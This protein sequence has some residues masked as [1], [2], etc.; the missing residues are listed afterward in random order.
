AYANLSPVTSWA[1]LLS[2]YYNNVG[3]SRKATNSDFFGLPLLARSVV[4]QVTITNVY[5]AEASISTPVNVYM[6]VV[7]RNI[8]QGNFTV[9]QIQ[10]DGTVVRLKSSK[11]LTLVIKDSVASYIN[12]WEAGVDESVFNWEV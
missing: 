7:G 8:S 1:D 2:G 10:A 9:D 11:I 4:P 3:T 12:S 5:P 6:E